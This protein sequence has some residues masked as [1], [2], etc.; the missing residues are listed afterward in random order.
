MRK[1]R[2]LRYRVDIVSVVMVS[3]VLGLQLA[4]LLLDWSWLL[5][6]PMIVLLRQVNLVEHNHAH[7]KIFHEPILNDAFGWLCFMSNGVPL[8]FYEVHHVRNHHCHNNDDQD[9]SSLFGFRGCRYPDKPISRA[10]YILS[11]PLLTICHSLIA[12]VRDPGSKV[13]R[14]FLRSVGVVAVGSVAL[15][16]V[17]PGGFMAFFAVPWVVVYFGLGMMNFRHHHGCDFN[18]P[19]TSCNV[20]TGAPFGWLGFNIGYH[21]SHHLKPGLHWSRLSEY[22]EGIREQIPTERFRPTPPATL[23][24]SRPVDGVG[25]VVEGK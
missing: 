24:P 10:Y 17:D 18:R 16:L 8:E 5:A 6:V 14:R 1:S 25:A 15:L 22:H 12:L 4:A 11:F 13:F 2:I 19:V 3:M 20:M 9:W 21:V 7:L 23:E